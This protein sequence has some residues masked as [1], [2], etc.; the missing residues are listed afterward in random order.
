MFSYLQLS[1]TNDG[2]QNNRQAPPKV[3]K[4]RILPNNEEDTQLGDEAVQRF[5]NLVAY[6]KYI[7]YVKEENS[8]IFKLGNS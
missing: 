6:Y 7:R 1:L 2:S 8:Y 5:S 4:T 3:A